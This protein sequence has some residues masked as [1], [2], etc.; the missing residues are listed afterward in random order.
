MMAWSAAEGMMGV[1]GCILPEDLIAALDP[2]PVCGESFYTAEG[3]DPVSLGM[4]LPD[5]ASSVTV[6]NHVCAGWGECNVGAEGANLVLAGAAA[7]LGATLVPAAT[8]YCPE[9]VAPAGVPAPAPPAPAPAPP[10]AP[11]PAPTSS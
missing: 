8:T 9:S 3:A 4:N 6:L 2:T 10:P 5:E 1:S 11:A 7:A